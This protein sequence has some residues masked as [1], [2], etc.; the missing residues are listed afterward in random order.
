MRYFQNS[1]STRKLLI[2]VYAFTTAINLFDAVRNP[3]RWNIAFGVIWP[4]LLLSSVFETRWMYWELADDC[5]KLR[6]LWRYREIPYGE[7]ASVSPVTGWRAAL[8]FQNKPIE[9][10][11][12]AGTKLKPYLSKS[13]E[14]L[15]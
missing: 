5:M 4:F 11:T 13:K 3:T 7:I 10:R 6:H 9:L 1:Q 14:F 15:A 8:S 12:V 2:G